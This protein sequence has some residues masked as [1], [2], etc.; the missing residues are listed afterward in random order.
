MARSHNVHKQ[1]TR[2]QSFDEFRNAISSSFVPLVTQSPEKAGFRGRL[3][4]TEIDRLAF[5][6]INANAH[7]VERTPELINAGGGGYYKLSIMLAGTSVLIQDNREL[8]L[9]AGDIAI[10]DTSRP[11]SLMFGEEFRNYVVMM[12]KDLVD[13]PQELVGEL[14]ASRLPANTHTGALVSQ[15]LLQVPQ[16]CAQTPSVVNSRLAHTSADLVETLLTLAL[17]TERLEQNPH[18]ALLRKIRDFI[19]HN[20]GLPDLSPAHIAA[21]HYIST[22]HLHGLFQ[23]QG[24]TVSAYIRTRRL[25]LCR[26]DLM[27]PMYADRP[28]S[29]VA[30]RWG[31][32]DAAHFSRV[33]RAQFNASPSEIRSEL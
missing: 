3:A 14:T 8:V 5:T 1:T 17:G 2:A 32:V 13:L 29:Q 9:Q 20:L 12:P 21:A 22:R 30:S 10:Y 33:F 6:E 25:E 24:M 26:Q 16:S 19:E 15:F 18:Q 27:N 11:Y 4:T 7:S 28:I 31:F 23:T